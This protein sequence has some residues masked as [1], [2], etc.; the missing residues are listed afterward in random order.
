MLD[1]DRYAFMQGATRLPDRLRRGGRL[2]RRLQ[3]DLPVG[4]ALSRADPDPRRQH[5]RRHLSG[6]R[7][8][9]LCPA[10]GLGP[11][12]HGDSLREFGAWAL[13]AAIIQILAFVIVSRVV[14]RK[15]AERIEAGEIAAAVYLASISICIGLLNAACMTA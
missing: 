12:A 5:R 3:A 10:A 1:F 13:L 8:D 6:R 9:R 7:P 4:H 15:L 11:V 2:H 14:F